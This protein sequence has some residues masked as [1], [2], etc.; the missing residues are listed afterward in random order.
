MGQSDHPRRV[1]QA[2]HPEAV[3][4]GAAAGE[5]LHPDDQVLRHDRAALEW[6]HGRPE[7]LDR[8]GAGPRP[9]EAG[10]V[11]PCDDLQLLELR[12]PAWGRWW[13]RRRP[14][15]PHAAESRQLRSQLSRD[16]R[17]TAAS[18]FPSSSAASTAVRAAASASEPSESHELLTG[19]DEMT[20]GPGPKQTDGTDKEEGR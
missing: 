3:R 13:W 1:L 2:P 5:P 18:A 10:R 12:E 15:T 16:L 9:R 19:R 4:G 7:H 11:R 14:S 17:A 8:A 6:A 20:D